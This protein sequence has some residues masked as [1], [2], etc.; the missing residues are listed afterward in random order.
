MRSLTSRQVACSE[1]S[2]PASCLISAQLYK[3]GTLPYIR[4]A[5]PYKPGTQLYIHQTQ[6]YKPG[7][8]LY[9]RLAKPYKPDLAVNTTE[10]MIN[11][12]GSSI[13]NSPQALTT[14]ENS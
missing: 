8:Q 10:T 1:R 6:P 11:K 9:I 7:T 3:P 2:R 5:Q 12:R 13:N 4:H 14:P